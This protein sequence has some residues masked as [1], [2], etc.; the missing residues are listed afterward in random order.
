MADLLIALW[1]L[2]LA[3]VFVSMPLF[4]AWAIITASP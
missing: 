1:I 3:I 2:V 4:M